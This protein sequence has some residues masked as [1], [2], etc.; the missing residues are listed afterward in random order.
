MIEADKLNVVLAGF[1]ATG[2][3]AAGKKLACRQERC[4]IDTDRV[5]EETAGLKIRQIF[6]QYG[7]SYFRERESEAIAGLSR[8]PAGS[9]VVATGGG[10][11][12]REENRRRLKNNSILILLT[13]APRTIL[14]RAGK[15]KIRPLLEGRDTAAKIKALLEEREHY[16]S[17]CDMSIDTTGKTVLQVVREIEGKLVF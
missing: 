8:Y 15:K 1:M 6:E 11:L 2:K 7:E 12:I 10:A 13:A 14:Y 16:Y 4:F 9:L 3:T 17:C 5:V